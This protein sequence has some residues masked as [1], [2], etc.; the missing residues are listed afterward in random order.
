M[1]ARLSLNTTIYY[2]ERDKIGTIKTVLFDSCLISFSKDEPN[3]EI[4]TD[5]LWPLF[6]NKDDLIGYNGEY[7]IIDEIISE[8]KIPKYK[9]GDGITILYNDVKIKSILKCEQLII[10]NYL[11]FCDRYNRT[12]R[13]LRKKGIICELLEYDIINVTNDI[14]NYIKQC[15]L[16]INK[17]NQ[18]ALYLKKTRNPIFQ[19]NN[20]I[21]NPYDFIQEEMQLITFE[22][23]EKINEEYQLNIPF[24]I[25]CIKWP[26]DLIRRYN[27]FYIP[28]SQ[29]YEEFVN[30]CKGTGEIYDR[31]IDIINTVI[32]DKEINKKNYKTTSY[33]LNLEK[34][35]T[36][37]I[38]EL[39]YDKTYLINEEELDIEIHKYELLRGS[40]FELEPEQKLS[41]KNTFINKLSIIT[42]FP[43]T[44]K[45]TII[46][47]ILYISHKLYKKYNSKNITSNTILLNIDYDTID[48]D[49]DTDDEFEETESNKQYV[50]FNN[51]SILAP[52][53][54]AFINCSDH[55][56]NEFN[57]DISGTCHKNIYNT[58]PK[59]KSCNKHHKKKEKC[60][61]EKSGCIYNCGVYK[62]IIDET[63]MIDIYMFRDILQWCNYF[64]CSL[65]IL[66][67][68][69]QLQSIGPGT[70]LKSI[71]DSKL[72]TVNTLT[73]I[74]RQSG[75]LM[76]N[77]KQMNDRILTS[78]DFNT[79]DM[80][81]IDID[82]FIQ[83]DKINNSFMTKF[84][85]KERLSKQFSIFL[86]YFKSDKF[87]FN[88]TNLNNNIQPLFND[89]V[90]D[91]ILSND[92]Y[93]KKYTFK[94]GDF[95]IRTENDYSDDKKF[96]ANGELAEIIEYD[97]YCVTIHYGQLGKE[98][99][100]TSEADT[101]KISVN[102]L[103]EQFELSYCL[104]VH[105][106][107]GS[108]FEN[109]VIFIDKKQSIWNKTALYTAISRAKKK[110]FIIS[111]Y[112]DFIKAQNNNTTD[113][114]SLFL[115]ES[116]VWEL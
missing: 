64:K 51:I 109:V 86:T 88:T 107:Q 48:Y 29:F 43:G 7:E 74:R 97:N 75:S 12:I 91:V 96:R 93:D 55:A 28:S 10:K 105:K 53:G 26:I 19:I 60:K 99:E 27:S 80:I 18:I 79:N 102:D 59:I 113:K 95:I 39:F 9:L 67:D 92:K 90:T 33:L 54:L 37:Q 71:I 115:K 52:T 70:I 63:S 2:K 14:L 49:T 108:Q 85:K 112:D 40:H 62:M 46:N 15:K 65:I 83:G 57:Q 56:E 47:C 66:G 13:F 103:Y 35:M 50:N 1:T 24:E 17:L 68:N 84:V 58:F 41:I 36:D 8:D 34:E 81:F 116:D 106:S 101:K 111:T 89:N 82:K 77:I 38:L 98:V 87:L 16:T 100:G 61:C 45:S 6:H 20:I 30:Y 76:I 73:E 69:N 110:C 23:A 4:K 104:T 94:I 5:K 44:G 42:G 78:T 32:I 22:K 3:K 31:Y 25:R 21:K 114:L 72:F 11:K